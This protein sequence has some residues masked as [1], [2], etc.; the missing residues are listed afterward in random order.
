MGLISDVPVL[1]TELMFFG[2]EKAKEIAKDILS[3]D[4][5]RVHLK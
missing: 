3:I 4:F 1:G 5:F 2:L